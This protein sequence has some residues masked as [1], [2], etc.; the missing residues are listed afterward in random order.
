M[1]IAHSLITLSVIGSDFARRNIKS[2]K[3]AFPAVPLESILTSNTQI[4]SAQLRPNGSPII[5][6]STGIAYSWNIDLCSL[7]K[8]NEL[9]WS[10]GSDQWEGKQ[11]S[12]KASTSKGVI[13]NLET[14]LTEMQTSDIIALD[15]AS[16]RPTW[17]DVAYTLGHLETRMHAARVLDSPA[18]YKSSL[19]HYA[20]KIA[21]EGYRAKAEELI[22]ELCGPLYW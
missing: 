9:R 5:I 3:A 4:T 17:W 19:A 20:R 16:E 8:I 18:E 6:L 1:S 22:K 7:V 2:G 13:A 15:D 11:R 21:E 12:N 10:L 14:T